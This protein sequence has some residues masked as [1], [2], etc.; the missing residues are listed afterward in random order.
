[1]RALQWTNFAGSGFCAP[2]GFGDS[3]ES[4]KCRDMDPASGIPPVRCVRNGHATVLHD[5]NGQAT[6]GDYS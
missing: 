5:S 6:E 2:S 1:M 3:P 4:S